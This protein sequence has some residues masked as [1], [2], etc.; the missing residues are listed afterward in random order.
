MFI[1]ITQVVPGDIILDG[2]NRTT[3]SK[4]DT[5]ICRQKTHINEK[6]CYENFIDVRVQD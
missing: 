3:V 2:S 5:K 1:N 4:V 6:D